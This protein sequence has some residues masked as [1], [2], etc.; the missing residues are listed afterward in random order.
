MCRRCLRSG[1]RGPSLLDL[2]LMQRVLLITPTYNSNKQIFEPLKLNE[3]DDVIEPTIDAL[4]RV[5][6]IVEEEKAEYDK[7]WEDLKK[8]KQFQRYL[9]SNTPV[10][11]IP[12]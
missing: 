2:K 6:S 9:S 12:S 10:E 11:G 8:Y 1:Q 4:K 3:K 5:T 7:Y